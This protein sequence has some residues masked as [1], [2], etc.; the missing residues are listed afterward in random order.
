LELP[1]ALAHCFCYRAGVV[2]SG[3]CH[4]SQEA[5]T[6]ASKISKE[7]KAELVCALSERYRSSP[8]RDKGRIL[9]E[10]VAV[11][12]YHRKHAIRLLLGGG[13]PEEAMR[14]G[15]RP[16]AGRQRRVYDEA[17][18]EALVVLW[19][20]A[21]RICGKRLKAVLPELIAALERHGHLHLDESVKERLLT[22][23]AATVDRLLAPVRSGARPRRKKRQ[24]SRAREEIAVRTFADWREPAPG[25]LEIDFVVHA[26]GSMSDSLIHTLVATDICSGWTECV[27]LLAR[28]Q[29]LVVEAL[30]ILSRQIPFPVRGVDSDNDGAFINET[31]VAFCKA[32]ELEFTRS[33]AYRK[34]D[35]AWVEQ[36]N[37]AVVRRLVGYQRFSGVVA[38]QVLAQLYQAARL[39]VNYF[40]PSAKLTEKRRE[41]GR[42]LRTHDC[43]ATPCARLLAHPAVDEE[44]KTVLRSQREQLDPLELLHRIREGQAALAALNSEASAVSELGRRSLEQFLAELPRLWHSGEVRPTHRGQAVASRYWRT[45]K[46]PFERAWPEIL[47]WLQREPDA[48]AKELLCRLQRMH[49]GDFPDGQLRTLQRRIREWRQVMA[50]KLVFGGLG[51]DEEVARPVVVGD[52]QVDDPGRRSGEA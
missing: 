15:S 8:K 25:Y 28:E 40:Q 52:V 23:S 22:I 11:S 17:V 18:T 45:R 36:K 37:G 27:P 13:S 29:S 1:V 41:G 50:R 38:G 2:A 16:D 4:Q 5:Y 24:P 35:Q 44:V 30:D 12:G 10:F 20:A 14:M 26:Q 48:T 46:D 51:G 3:L 34:N 9:D 7:T 32:R 39:Y 31:L 47:V 19:E 42:I 21:D 49:P 43:P 33:R 6:M